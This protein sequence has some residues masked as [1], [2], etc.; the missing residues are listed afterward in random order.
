MH[1]PDQFFNMPIG[2]AACRSA[3][4]CARRGE[5]GYRTAGPMATRKPWSSSAASAV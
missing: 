3:A 2:T 5:R 4:R 1:R